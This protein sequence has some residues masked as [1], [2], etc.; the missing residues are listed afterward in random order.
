MS[1]RISGH[2]RLHYAWVNAGA[3]MLV[4]FACGTVSQTYGIFLQAM[5]QE[6]G[7]S[8]GRV[9]GA[10]TLLN[11]VMVVAGP[12]ITRLSGR[13]GLRRL[14]A[15]CLCGMAAANLLL[16]ACH[17]LLPVYCL[18]ALCGR[19]MYLGMFQPCP[20]IVNR[21]FRV[22]VAETIS[23]IIMAMAVG[24]ACGNGT[25]SAV[26][27]V[28]SWRWAYRAEAC[29]LL[30]VAAVSALLL[31]EDPQTMGLTAYGSE[32][33]P[34]RRGQT[35]RRAGAGL[36]LGQAVKRPDFW[37]VTLYMGCMQFC[38]SM[39]SQIPTL[40]VSIGLSAA[41][42]AAAAS[43]N[44]LGGIPA[45]ALLS[46]LNVRLGVVPSV[47]LYGLVGIAGILGVILFPGAAGLQVFALLF[48][49]T[50]GSSTVQLPLLS[51]R[52]FGAS[53]EYGAI[54]ARIVLLSG[55]LATP[56]ALVAGAV[57]DRSGSYT[58]FLV[59]L[60]V[61]LVMSTVFAK[62]AWRRTTN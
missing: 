4:L 25:L 8:M 18:F 22:R 45:K 39:Q 32:R 3:C 30:A 52:L 14:L 61:L 55:L 2:G 46:V 42:G 51:N 28:T 16:S 31:R 35:D 26:L 40:A 23:V 60:A 11:L 62:A 38:V 13:V 50:I 17:S 54:H 24:G 59:L 58:L 56:S 57:Y 9:S 20:C 53:P 19:C 5:A 41:A 12:L 43:L 34:E 33:P 27:H 29:F 37:Y 21:W 15:V 36:A 7:V 49:F 10:V 6:M 44:S 47:A 1:G 48:G